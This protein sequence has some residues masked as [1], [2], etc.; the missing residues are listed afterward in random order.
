MSIFSID[1][2]Q[3]I[4]FYPHSQHIALGNEFIDS[5]ALIHH[6]GRTLNSD[7]SLN[8]FTMVVYEEKNVVLSKFGHKILT[9][10]EKKSHRQP[11]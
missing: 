3:S 4:K 1:V 10:R 2:N 8:S 7:W 9:K 5:M 11:L 6:A